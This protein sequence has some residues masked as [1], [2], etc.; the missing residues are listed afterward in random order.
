MQ[1][2]HRDK[3]V[4]SLR[5]R[6]MLGAAVTVSLFMLALFPALQQ[7]FT[8]SL[9]QAIEQRLAADASALISAARINNGQLQ[10]PE[11]LPDEEFDILPARQLGFIYDDKGTVL[12]RSRSSEDVKI[13]YQP[14]YDGHG[15]EF[16]R[17]KDSEGREFFIYD[18]EV[19]LLRGKSADFSIVTMQP[20][21]DYQKMYDSLRQQL[22]VWLGFALLL[23][24]GF[25][26][27]GLGWG[28]RSLR[29]LSAELDDVE[30]GKRAALS[31]EHPRELLRLTRSLNRLL[32]SER[33]QSERYRHSLDD[34]A[35]SL[36][37]PLAVLQGVGEV[38]AAR[39]DN[40]EQAGTLLGQVNRMSQQISYQ[41]QRASLRKSGLLRYQV[42][43]QPLLSSLLVALDKV[44]RDKNVRVQQDFS[45]EL[46]VP[47][48]QGA[49]LELLGNILENAYRLSVSE[50]RISAQLTENCCELIVEDD[51]PGVPRHQRE[52]ILQRGERLDTQYPGQGIGIAVVKDIIGSYGGEFFVEDSDLG[53]AQFRVVFPLN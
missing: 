38:L 22:Y 13:N 39:P 18:V 3:K 50:I 5:M 51:G 41:L 20:V 36:K 48:E 32:E 34:L 23:L 35:H 52:R 40:A 14:K 47:V 28:I 30:T 17:A 21:S 8:Q 45:A 6:L 12:W 44:Y 19:D 49:L 42:K 4:T 29:S 16:L 46:R 9:E 7:V 26:W 27:L 33:Q 10:M 11:K 2:M 25:L 15:H 1:H 53:G 24:L 43:L 37:T 31:D